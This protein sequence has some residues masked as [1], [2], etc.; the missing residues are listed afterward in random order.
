MTQLVKNP[1]ATRETWVRSLGWEDPLEKGTAT[2]SRVL[3]WR[4]PWIQS[5]GSKRVRHDWATFAFGLKDWIF[6]EISQYLPFQHR[7]GIQ[8]THC[9]SIELSVYPVPLVANSKQ[10][11]KASQFS[12]VLI[13]NLAVMEYFQFCGLWQRAWRIMQGGCQTGTQQQGCNYFMRVLVTPKGTTKKRK[14]GRKVWGTSG[15]SRVLTRIIW[16]S[17]DDPLCKAA[18]ETQM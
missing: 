3:A 5:T 18:R 7:K 15:L 11:L 10:A 1:P 12:F 13:F 14:K 9:F 2:H 4:I 6:V 16:A 8:S 17:K